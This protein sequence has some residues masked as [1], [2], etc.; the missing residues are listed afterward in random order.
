MLSAGT[1]RL[2][3]TVTDSGIGLANVSVAVVEGVGDSLTTTTNA[4]GVYALYGVRDRV[5][6][7]ASGTGYFN[8][9]KEVDVF[10][11]RTYDFEMRIDRP[12]TDLRG[13]YRL[14]IDRNPAK[15][16]GCTGRDPELPDTRSYDATV[17]QDGLRLTVT[18]S[19][20]DFIVT[21]GRGNTFSG[22]IDGSDR[23]TF[24]LGD[25]D[26]YY[27][28]DRVQ[29]LVERIGTTGQVLVIT[30]KVTAGLSPSRISGTL[31]G[32][33][34]Y[35]EGGGPPFRILQNNCYSFTTHRFE[36]VRQ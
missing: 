8:E 4:D 7:Q 2:R 10:D 34:L 24:V 13:R 36:M 27:W 23:V 16:S 18:L 32:W 33:F 19:G 14:T 35:V 15:G 5:R 3:G 20:A 6:L 1:Y 25:Q 21:R 31:A 28:E 22:T 17:D 11:H 26:L 9:I 30:G 29:D 12:R